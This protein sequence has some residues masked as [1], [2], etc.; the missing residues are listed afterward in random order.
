VSIESTVYGQDRGSV[1]MSF[2]DARLASR[3]TGSLAWVSLVEPD[4]NDFD[5]I[6]GSLG[7]DPHLLEEAAKFPHRSGVEKHESRLVAVLPILPDSGEGNGTVGTGKS[8]SIESDWILV[9]AAEEPNMIVT[10]TDGDHLILDKL[11]RRVEE[12]LDLLARDSE[13]IL[14]EIVGE[15]VGDYE[16]AVETIDG[17]IWDAEA[18]VMEGRSRDTLR[19]IHVLTRQAVG[20]QQAIKPLATALEQLTGSDA[21]V[22]QRQL[23]RIRHRA[24]RVTE[25]LDGARDLLSSLLQVNLT[26]VGQKISAWGAILIVPS[27]I[28]GVFGMNFDSAWL[29]KADHGFEMMLVIMF[30]ISGSLYLWFKRSG[31]L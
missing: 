20:L 21:P 11:H 25:K 22:A 1:S 23:S 17:C 13:A 30:L 14:L 24:L 2:A 12:R 27:L 15:V 5:V 31:W 26:V 3:E 4:V 29:K 10:L 16:R 18:R 28:A 9:V 7:L 6:S 19:R 8:R